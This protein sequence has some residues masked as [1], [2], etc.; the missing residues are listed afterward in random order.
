MKQPL[1]QTLSG[2]QLGYDQGGIG[3]TSVQQSD[4]NFPISFESQAVH[5]FGSAHHPSQYYIKGLVVRSTSSGNVYFSSTPSNENF[6]W[7]AIGY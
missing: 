4:F 1:E 7:C 5:L 6:F 2:L 3:K